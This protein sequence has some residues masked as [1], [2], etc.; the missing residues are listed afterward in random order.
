[1]CLTSFL[2][3]WTSISVSGL[4]FWVSELI[5][6]VSGRA[7]GRTRPPAS[8]RLGGR[9]DPPACKRAGGRMG[10]RADKRA[11]NPIRPQMT[12]ETIDIQTKKL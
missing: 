1:M 8:E 11:V 7:D 6:G 5:L 4:V 9:A 2:G 3:V 12:S 10:G